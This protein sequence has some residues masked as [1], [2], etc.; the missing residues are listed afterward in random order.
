MQR[1]EEKTS[2]RKFHLAC[3]FALSDTVLL[4]F[5]LIDSTIWFNM[6]AAVLGL[7]ALGNVGAKFAERE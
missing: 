3:Y 2:N 5:G 4:A 1:V 6:G 7:Y